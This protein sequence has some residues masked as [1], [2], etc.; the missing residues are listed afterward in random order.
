MD[1]EIKLWSSAF[2]L[3]TLATANPDLISQMLD[4]MTDNRNVIEHDVEALVF[5]MNGG[6]DLNDAWLLTVDQR[7]RM[8]SIIEKH[9]E[10]QNPNRKSNL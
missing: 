2:F 9:F 1:R 10:A 6:L 7:K 8:S 4:V 3:S 5:Y